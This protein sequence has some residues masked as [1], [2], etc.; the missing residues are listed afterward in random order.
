MQSSIDQ[1]MDEINFDVQSPGADPTAD[2]AI[3]RMMRDHFKTIPQK[4]DP[5][6]ATI[7]EMNAFGFS[8][9]EIMLHLKI[10][11]STFYYQLKRIRDRWKK[12]ID[13]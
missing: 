9:D 1:L 4:E 6:L 5:T 13:D 3:S 8:S 10:G 11:T 2:A 7:F 12:F